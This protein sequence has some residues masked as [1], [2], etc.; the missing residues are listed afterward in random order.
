MAGLMRWVDEKPHR[1]YVVA[2]IHTVL[3][4][5]SIVLPVALLLH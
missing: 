5:I 2:A 4:V 1:I 3:F